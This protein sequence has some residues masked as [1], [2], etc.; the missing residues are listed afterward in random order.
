MKKSFIFSIL[1]L[2]S[3]FCF[4]QEKLTNQS[5]LDLIELGFGSEVIKAKINSSQVEFDTSLLKLKFLKEK[6]VPSDVLAL[7]IDKSKT[8]IET[9][10]FYFI[11]NDLKK[12]VPI[13]FS[14]TKTSALGA[15]WTYGIVSKK[16]KSYI[17]N[18]NSTNLINKE[19]Q[20]FIF[21]LSP[22]KKNNFE[23]TNWYWWFKVATS[24]R[25]FV[26]TKLKQK[27][28][29]NQRELVTGKITG[30]TKSS[31]MGIDT[32]DTIPFNIEDL[33]NNVYKI[34]PNT[35]LKIGEYCFF[36]QGTIPIGEYNNQYIFD[37]SIR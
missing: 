37:F 5:I 17:H 31:Q 35:N 25:E 6:G 28:R 13:T 15:V 10:I 20:T 7:M 32:K 36:Y 9:G 4:S 19:E 1:L 8:E 12:I 29:Q 14:G 21:I 26:L 34:T 16:T 33:G 18:F 3:I 30:I 2:S 22:N 23:I 11:N 24:P 27:K